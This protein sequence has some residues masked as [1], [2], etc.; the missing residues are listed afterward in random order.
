[1]VKWGQSIITDLALKSSIL[2][3][4]WNLETVASVAVIFLRTAAST[5]LHKPRTFPAIELILKPVSFF[6]KSEPNVY[7]DHRAYA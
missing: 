4:F 7:K 3:A 2:S 5:S 6:G 1:V